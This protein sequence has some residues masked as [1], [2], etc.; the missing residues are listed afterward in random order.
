MTPL[1]P[2]ARTALMGTNRQPLPAPATDDEPGRL[3][4]AI[5][6]ARATA[7]PEL[8][9]L[10]SAGVI[11]L[12]GQAGMRP[13]PVALEP[14][15][16]S[17][18]ESRTLVEHE[19][20]KEFLAHLI[21]HP[22]PRLLIEALRELA[23]RRLIV[24]FSFLPRLLESG[25]HRP[26][27]RPFLQPVL[28]ERGAWLARLNPQFG[29]ALG[30]EAATEA[31][32]DWETATHPA[33]RAH[34]AHLRRTAPEQA[35]A[36][37]AS[38]FAKIPA[39]ERAELLAEWRAGL[40]M[41]DEPFLEN[42]LG[43]R[44]REVRVQA[45]RLLSLLPESRLVSRMGER[46]ASCLSRNQRG[47]W[48]MT[49][50]QS[51]DPLWA[52]DGILEQFDSG[53]GPRAGWLQQIA[54]FLP[55]AWWEQHLKL[56]PE[57]IC[58]WLVKSDWAKALGRAMGER[59]TQEVA[60]SWVKVVLDQP[61]AVF[62][63]EAFQLVPRL[64]E[65]EQQDYWLARL[66]DP[67]GD[68]RML[69]TELVQW[70]HQ[71]GR[72]LQIATAL[73]ALNLA[74]RLMASSPSRFRW[75]YEDLLLVIPASL[76]TSWLAELQLETPTSEAETADLAPYIGLLSLRQQLHHLLDQLGPGN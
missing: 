70:A 20:F 22:K 40:S 72:D 26:E 66:H 56:T 44:S 64:P 31:E 48:V 8:A 42:S 4:A 38:D 50:P 35:R 69:L 24:P 39:K 17:P 46:L 59:L 27:L 25:R 13:L 63:L 10:Q 5:A 76:V 58:Q 33:R 53:Q 37:L 41:E 65:E 9:L 47:T 61:K 45:A 57:E 60:P 49:P 52:R 11:A 54:T 2:L 21:E 15:P 23:A 36:R 51:F 43:D 68:G 6:A 62:G 12:C 29:W 19:G 74:A 1:E 75:L 30:T 71:S 55:L 73:A 32:F 67:P 14:F 7:N 16:R 3:L 18:P 28:G 34:L